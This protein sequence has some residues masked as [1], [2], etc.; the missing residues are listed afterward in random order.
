MMGITIKTIVATLVVLVV[1][2]HAKARKT[3]TNLLFIQDRE[4][5]C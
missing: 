5:M 1:V 3:E 2:S 4:A